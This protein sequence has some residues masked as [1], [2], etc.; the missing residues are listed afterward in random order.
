MKVHNLAQGSPEWRALRAA[1]FCASEAPAMMGCSPYLLRTELLRQK[2]TGITP[3]VDEA[4]QRRLDKGHAAEAAFRPI[5]ESG[6][7]D[8]LYPCTGTMSVEGLPL[9]ASF[10]GLTLDRRAGFEHKLLNGSV[11]GHMEAHGEPP[12]HYVW[13]LEQQ[14][15]VSGA[16]RILFACGD[17]TEDNTKLC[18]YQSKPERRAGLIAGWHQFAAD[19]AIYTPPEIVAPVTAAP[20]E[21]LPVVSIRLDGAVAIIDNLG[22]F[23][24]RLRAFVQKLPTQPSTDQEF[25]DADHGCKVLQEAQDALERAEAAALAQTGDIEQMRRTVATYVELART[26]RLTLEKLVKARKEQIKVEIVT[27]GQNAL[28]AHVAD[29]NE[30]LGRPYITNV[31]ADFAGAIKGKRTIASLREAVNVTL[32]N[33][34]LAA[35][36]QFAQVQHNLNLLREHA[37]E[38]KRLFPD[39]AQLVHKQSDDLMAVI[40]SRIAEQKDAE[41]KLRAEQA[42][43]APPAPITPAPARVNEAPTLT[44]SQISER[45]GLTVT[46]DFLARLGFAAAQVKASKCYR[47]SD[48]PAIC[49]HLVMH[50]ESVAGPGMYDERRAA[51]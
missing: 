23:G 29:L 36:A 12:M 40:T 43:A 22:V 37:S 16:E 20:V 1:H 26:T 3:D 35:S 8:D 2:K 50:I 19:L 17:G 21:A 44:L 39:T 45:L 47:P 18:W 31:P 46:A 11:I 5:A 51:E 34:K 42:A 27:E 38:H 32:T 4:S 30:K 33:C 10:D 9:L 13:Q 7:N 24:D 49:L 41:A 48:F 25:A 28:T 14:L 6:I 15:L